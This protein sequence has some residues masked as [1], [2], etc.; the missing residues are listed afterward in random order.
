LDFSDSLVLIQVEGEK[1]LSTSF[2]CA[3]ARATEP[4]IG[5]LVAG[6]AA[7]SNAD[8]PPQA[9]EVFPTPLAAA[10]LSVPSL[11]QPKR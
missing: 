3:H 6:C 11:L 9:S 7:A 5:T 1:L 10:D 4:E 8:S 2:S